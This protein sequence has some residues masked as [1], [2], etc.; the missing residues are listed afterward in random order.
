MKR[1][2]NKSFWFSLAVIYSLTLLYFSLI[3]IKAESLP[4]NFANADKLFHLGAYFGLSFLWN[5]FYLAKKK[6]PKAIPN[7]WIGVAV[8]IFGIIIEILQRDLT[9]YRGFEWLD[10]VANSSGVI[11][12]HIFLATIGTKF[13]AKHFY[14]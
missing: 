12:C 14:G 5:F 10:I 2:L 4:V 9:T 7:V 6:T 3:R 8:I 1:I 13:L 11:L